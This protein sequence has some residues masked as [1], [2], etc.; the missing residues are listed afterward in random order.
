MERPERER[1][2]CVCVNW[3]SEMNN[4]YEKKYYYIYCYCYYHHYYY[5]K[6]LKL[7]AVLIPHLL[8]DIFLYHKYIIKTCWQWEKWEREKCRIEKEIDKKYTLHTDS[9]HRG[10]N[11][12]RQLS[13]MAIYPETTN[14][15]I[16]NPCTYRNS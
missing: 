15:P 3:N 4:V 6:L 8:L 13:P 10:Q 11:K 7:M 16:T 2:E 9:R 5:Y 12:T 1:R 14:D